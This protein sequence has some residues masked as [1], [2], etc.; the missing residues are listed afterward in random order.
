MWTVQDKLSAAVKD[1]AR[2]KEQEKEARAI[3]DREA[4]ELL[5]E[6]QK[7]EG[8]ECMIK[9]CED[10]Y[11]KF[12]K[13]FFGWCA[14]THTDDA[15]QFVKGYS[16]GE[17]YEVLEISFR[18]SLKDQVRDRKLYLEEQR[19][20]QEAEERERDLMQMERIREKYGL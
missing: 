14:V 8:W 17:E 12:P 16:N 1:Y 19:R 6:L 20:K 18:R 2:Y 11:S 15:V 4:R 5:S 10:H 3:I 13:L 7:V 9:E